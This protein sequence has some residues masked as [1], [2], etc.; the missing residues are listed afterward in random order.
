LTYEILGVMK[1]SY[2]YYND[3]RLKFTEDQLVTNSKFDRLYR[4]DHVGQ[5]NIAL[6]GQE[7][8][9]QDTTNDRPYNETTTYDA[10]GH[11]TSRDVRQRIGRT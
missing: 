2:E 10:F 6:S 9:E 5:I 7:A 11:L 3:G 8:R 1:K 4:Y